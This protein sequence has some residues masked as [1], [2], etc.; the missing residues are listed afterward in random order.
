MFNF[1][2]SIDWKSVLYASLILVIIAIILGLVLAIA[3]K[4]LT[5]KND[6]RKEEVMKNM[7]NVNCGACGYPGCAGLV[8]ALL[9][10]EVKK[11][12]ACKVIKA[13]KKKIIADYLNS[14]KDDKGNTLKVS[15]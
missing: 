7:P 15:E 13:D 12:S 6:P 5:I 11:V 3:N 9:S 10:G 2:I 4:F 1:L 8:D 14:T